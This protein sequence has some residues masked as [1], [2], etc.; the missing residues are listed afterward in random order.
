VFESKFLKH[1]LEIL[2]LFFIKVVPGIQ[3]NWIIWSEIENVR[4]P[5]VASGEK[6]FV[7]ILSIRVLVFEVIRV[8]RIMVG[9]NEQEHKA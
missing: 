3:R 2:I 5:E 8:G 1:L 4:L 7:K 6:K 9:E